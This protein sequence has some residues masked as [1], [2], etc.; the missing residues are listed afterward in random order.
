MWFFCQGAL[1]AF[2]FNNPGR[3]RI[4]K[5]PPQFSSQRCSNVKGSIC[6]FCCC[7]RAER[8]FGSLPALLSQYQTS[9]P[10]QATALRCWPI[11]VLTI[12]SRAWPSTRSGLT[13][14]ASRVQA[15]LPAL[16]CT[17]QRTGGF[18]EH[19]FP[20]FHINVFFLLSCHLW[21][22]C[23]YSVFGGEDGNLLC[24][25]NKPKSTLVLHVYLDPNQKVQNVRSLGRRWT[26]L[27]YQSFQT[28]AAWTS[29]ALIHFFFS[30]FIILIGTKLS[31]LPKITWSNI[32]VPHKTNPSTVLVSGGWWEKQ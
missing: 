20:M 2:L 14:A 17:V 32:A 16:L 10:F 18:G 12:C 21:R 30:I 22:Y 19:T 6:F 9:H 5:T 3:S 23:T 1:P 31:S 29:F 28:E 7:K 13:D 8:E 4:Q 24:P 25:L 15:W 26:L 11:Q 27:I